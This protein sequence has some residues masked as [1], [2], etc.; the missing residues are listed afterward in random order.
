MGYRFWLSLVLLGSLLAACSG[1]RPG[2][3][4]ETPIRV[5]NVPVEVRQVTLEVDGAPYP[6]TQGQNGWTARVRL[7]A[8]EHTFIAR[9]WD[10][11]NPSEGIVLYKAHERRNVTP[12]QEV[13]LTLYRLTSDVEVVVEN[14]Q[15]GEVYVAKTGGSEAALPGGRG[16]LQGVPTGRNVLLLVE[17]RDASGT[18]RRQGSAA[19]DLSEGARTVRLSLSL[20]AHEPPRVALTGADLVERGQPYTLSIQAEDPNPESSGV[21]LTEL[22][23]DWGDG[24]QETIPLSGRQAS[25]SRSHTYTAAGTFTI[26]AQV[27]SSA[28]LRA[29]ASKALQVLEQETSI[30]ITPAPDLTRVVLEVTGA[31]E[32]TTSLEAEISP[33][34]P[35]VPQSLRPLDLKNQYRLALYPQGGA[36]RGALSL[37]SGL[38]YRLVLVAHTPGGP[39]RSREE[40]FRAEGAELNL[41]KAFQAQASLPNCPPPDATLAAT[42]EVQGSGD[43]SPLEGQTV[44]VQGVVT[45]VFPGLRGFYIQ[46]PGGDNDPTTSDGLFVYYGNLTVSVNPGQYVQ[47]KGTVAEYAAS[48]DTLGTL[49]QLSLGAASH[50]TVCGQAEI[51]QAATLVLPEANL[52]RLEGMRVRLANLTVVDLYNLG[53]YGEVVLAPYRLVHPNA[54]GDSGARLP[55]DKLPLPNYGGYTLILDDASTQQNPNP[56]PYLPQGGTLRVGDRLVEAQGV[57]EWRYGGYRV[58]PIQA[59]SFAQANPRPQAPATSNQL[60]VASFNLYNWFTT[61][62]GTFTPPGCSVSHQPRGATNSQEFERQKA[63]LV[64]AFMALDADVVALQEVQ[65]NGAEALEALVNALNQAV[66]AGTYAYV[67]DPQGGL[68]CDAIKVGFLYKPA[69]VEPVGN[70]LALANP[71]FERYPLAQAFRDKST[72]GVFV[73]VSVHF[74]SKSGCDPSDPDTGQGCWN[75]RRTAQAQALRDWVNET[76]KNVDADILLLGDFNSYENEDP[77]VLLRD[78]GL[79]PI[80][81]NHYTYVFRGLSGA[82]DHAY[83]TPSLTSQT[84]GGLVW[85]IN[86]DEPRVLDYTL[87]FKPDDRYQPNPYRS[88]DHD[89]LLV[90]LEL[91]PECARDGAPVV[92]NEF[93]FRGPNG[94]NDEFIELF[95][96]S[97]S[98]VNLSG[99][100]LQGLSATGSWG[101][102][103]T[104]ANVT[105]AP[106]QYYLLANTSSGGYSLSA[107]PDQTYG[108]G[109]A[110]NRAVRLL[111]AQGQV[112]DLVG[113]ASSGQYEGTGLPD[114]P[115]SGVSTQISWKRIP[116][117]K[118]TN[119]NAQDF[120]Y[121]NDWANPQNKESAFYGPN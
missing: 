25:L 50:L 114:G 59:P 115:T 3:Q 106:G 99:W 58:Q 34:T 117:G 87:S 30:T 98:P 39:V 108:T 109:V 63:K 55:T 38:T 94:G 51:P 9:G 47:V 78:G 82:L 79:R 54:G 77:L 60:R 90:H 95:N 69:R 118:D 6:V 40:A 112:V 8:G 101:D 104:L 42:Y 31:P 93:R 36:W 43:R 57:L 70:P 17:A 110:D 22:L 62:S 20:V 85:H 105:L 37:P 65:N 121:G 18:L 86:A 64:A 92:V 28:G 76:L 61:F 41:Q 10:R 88:S 103:V 7:S 49:T 111:D 68:G 83:A 45:A 27:A 29:Q 72:G 19:F 5:L 56:I 84:R 73:A 21:A 33:E 67:A 119:N 1:P 46:D 96:R 66:G 2:A 97:C 52:E 32:G 35:L 81:S 24:N 14:P 75:Q 80:L 15:D 89:P 4:G 107:Q 48:G 13:R 116:S 74:K 100:K 102:R 23:L 53:R 16:T 113:F 91:A 26:T 12:G 71:V 11:E 120:Q 44:A